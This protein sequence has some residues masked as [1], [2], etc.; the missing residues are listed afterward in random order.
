[1][2]KTPSPLRLALAALLM[3]PLPLAA[4]GDEGEKASPE[5]FERIRKMEQAEKAKEDYLK[6]LEAEEAKK[7]AEA[8]PPLPPIATAPVAAWPGVEARL[9]RCEPGSSLVSVEVE[10]VNTGSAPVTIEN[11]SATEATIS[12]GKHAYEV[13]RRASG[14]QATSGLTATLAPGEKTAV[15][16]TFP[17]PESVARVTIDLPGL[18]K[19]ENVAPRDPRAVTKAPNVN[20]EDTKGAPRAKKSS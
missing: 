18:V 9:T 2:K 13:L 6:G 10:L 16:A 7:A 1:M 4:C 5:E 12:D 20:H 19:F 11:Y 8:A 15:F 14:S 17:K 3:A